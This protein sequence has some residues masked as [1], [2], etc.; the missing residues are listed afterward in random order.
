[1]RGKFFTF[2]FICFLYHHHFHLE[3]QRTKAVQ[4]YHIFIETFTRNITFMQLTARCFSASLVL[5]F[6]SAMMVIKPTLEFASCVGQLAL[7]TEQND[8]FAHYPSTKEAG[9]QVLTFVSW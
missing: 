6:G 3:K 1:M 7:H 2:C 9:F 5:S 4:E 8:S